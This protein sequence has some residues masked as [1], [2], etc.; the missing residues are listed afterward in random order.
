M[1][2]GSP[3]SFVVGRGDRRLRRWRYQD[4][5]TVGAHLTFWAPVVCRFCLAERG[6][7]GSRGLYLTGRERKNRR[8]GATLEG[9]DWLLASGVAPRRLPSPTIIPWAQAHGYHHAVAPRLPQKVRCDSPPSRAHLA[10]TT[11]LD[12]FSPQRSA[13]RGAFDLCL[14][15]VSAELLLSPTLS[16]TPRRKGGLAVM[17]RCARRAPSGLTPNRPTVRISG[18]P[19]S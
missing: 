14:P 5:P 9:L 13:G 7:D 6:H 3:H 4:S 2:P 16:S 10:T 18:S 19:A 12:S 1:L 11:V 15:M 8:R 17:S